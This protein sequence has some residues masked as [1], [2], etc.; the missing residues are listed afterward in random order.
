L[1]TRFCKDDLGPKFQHNIRVCRIQGSP[2]PI[3]SCTKANEWWAWEGCIGK[4]P[5]PTY[6]FV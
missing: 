1:T 2:T 3:H 4:N 5:S 6:R